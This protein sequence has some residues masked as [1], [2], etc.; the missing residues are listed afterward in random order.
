MLS[1]RYGHRQQV[2]KAIQKST[3][4]GSPPEKVLKNLKSQNIS[5]AGVGVMEALS[6]LCQLSLLF[7]PLQ[8]YSSSI[9]IDFGT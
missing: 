6:P 3:H 4:L 9:R 2:L 5:D 8:L 7:L 1:N